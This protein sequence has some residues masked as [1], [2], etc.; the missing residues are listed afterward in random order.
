[1]SQR[2]IVAGNNFLAFIPAG[3]AVPAAGTTTGPSPI[4]SGLGQ[5]KYLIVEAQMV[6][7]SGGT[8]ADVYIQT[9]LDQGASWTDIMNFH[10]LTANQKWVQSV[11]LQTALVAVAT[12]TVQDGALGAGT[13]ATGVLGDR[14]R[15]KLVVVGAYVA[16]LSV[17]GWVKG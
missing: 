14:F 16:T 4:P 7:T 15:Y 11:N 3:T 13:A 9:S 8:T 1:M 12:Y 2:Q 17:T 5:S 6:Y 10:F